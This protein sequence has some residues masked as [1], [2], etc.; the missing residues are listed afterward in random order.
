MNI[1]LYSTLP[2]L[3]TAIAEWLACMVYIMPR[4]KRFN[5]WGLWAVSASFLVILSFTNQF[6][7]HLDGWPWILLMVVG[8]VEMYLMIYLCC[9]AGFWKALYH[10]AHAFI[11]AEFAAS[12]EWQLNCY[13]IYSDHQINDGIE[14]AVMG[15]VYL[16]VF[17]TLAWLN[18]KKDF[19]KSHLH[20]SSREAIAAAG[21][22]LSMFLLS[23]FAF[24]F[25]DSV[26]S[27]TMGAGVLFV[28]T[29][30]DLSG[31][32]MLYAH[33][34]QRRE[35]YLQ[36]ELEAMDS[37]LNRQ[38]EQFKLAQVNNEA[39]HRVYHDLKHQI[40]FIKAEPDEQKKASYLA[41]METVVNIHEAEAVTGNSVLDTI[42]TSKNLLCAE[43]RIT[44]TCFADATGLERLDAMDI[45][46]IF[47]N[48]I[49][50]AIEYEM[51][52]PEAEKRLIKVAVYQENRF[53]LIRIENYCE[54]QILNLENLPKTKK[55]DSR[56]HGYGLKSI[57]RTA[58]KYGGSM[59][60][61]QEDEWFTMTVLIPTEE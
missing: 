34:E 14:Y 50:N 3:H 21:I 8:L 26:V 5:R 6:R 31:L 22:A 18:R 12:L 19:M 7:T 17:G 48:A 45:C 11:A 2:G 1:E 16:A 44:M 37:L 49:D 20:T 27:T 10:W 36:H 40:A 29:L 4:S 24:A 61:S 51:N 52:I 41:E 28:R 42:L 60:L 25:R 43:H 30:S 33:D 59:T 39:M 35:I 58:E 15:I 53:L 13:Y 38:Y 9:R 56:F 47:G 57:R 55:E 32:F 46:S 54:E 23:N